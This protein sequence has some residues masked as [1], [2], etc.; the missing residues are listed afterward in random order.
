[1]EGSR[2]ILVK[3][4]N[5]VEFFGVNNTN[6]KYLKKYF[7]QL[8]IASRGNTLT[9][10]GE[11]DLIDQFEHKISIN[12]K[13]IVE[14]L[15][16]GNGPQQMLIEGSSLW[17]SRTYYS[18]DWTETYYGTSQIDLLSGSIQIKEYDTGVVCGGDMMKINEQAYRTFEG[19]V[20][21]MKSDLTINRTSKMTG[22][23]PFYRFVR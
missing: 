23:Y 3:S 18:P 10:S 5:P 21:R 19:G 15:Q 8:K 13:Q 6:L 17:I 12:S 1:M 14:T 22:N 9:L 11:D 16:V 4:T 7:P 20:A 2:K